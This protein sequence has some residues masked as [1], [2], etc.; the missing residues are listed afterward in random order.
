MLLLGKKSLFVFSFLAVRRSSFFF[1]FIFFLLPFFFAVVWIGWDHQSPVF[2]AF[3]VFESSFVVAVV[4]VCCN[5]SSSSS[6]FFVEI[7]GYF[8]VFLECVHLLFLRVTCGGV[9]T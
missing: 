6:S 7:F 2:L 9:L 1:F 8:F 4:V 5:S 3:F